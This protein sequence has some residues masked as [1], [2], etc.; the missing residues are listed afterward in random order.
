MEKLPV[1][2]VV[3]IIVIGLCVWVFTGNSGINHSLKDGYERMK[4][5]V[6]KN[7]YEPG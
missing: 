7:G 6:R 3:A 1:M 5:E 4:S 2:I